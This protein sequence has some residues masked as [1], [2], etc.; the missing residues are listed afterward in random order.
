MGPDVGHNAP[1]IDE[2]LENIGRN[3]VV[4]EVLRVVQGQLGV[5]RE[6]VCEL[7]PDG[8]RPSFSSIP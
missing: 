1:G 4:E 6:D 5:L 8:H 2:V 7:S 3:H